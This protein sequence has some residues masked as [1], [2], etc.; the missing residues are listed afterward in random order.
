[1][2]P[3]SQCSDAMTT[4]NNG[5]AQPDCS[6]QPWNTAPSI[7]YDRNLSQAEKSATLAVVKF[8]LFPKY[9]T[10][11][12]SRYRGNRAHIGKMTI[13]TRGLRPVNL[14]LKMFE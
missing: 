2:S 3:L 11:S 9:P 7:L 6:N 12:I 10:Y 4:R 13:S 8:Q 14:N 1:M 5:N